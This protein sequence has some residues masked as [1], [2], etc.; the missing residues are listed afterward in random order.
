MWALLP[1]L[2]MVALVATQL[3]RDH[4]IVSRVHRSGVLGPPTRR[5]GLVFALLIVVPVVFVRF[6]G[7]EGVLA[8][9]SWMAM[10]VNVVVSFLISYTWYRYLTW[11]DPFAHEG[12]GWVLATFLL[13]CVVVPLVFPL[14]EMAESGL[15]LRLDGTLWNDWW[16]CSIAIG[17]TEEIVKLIPLLAI[18]LF[19][20]QAD[21]PFDLILY[22]SISALAFAF[23]EN[24]DYLGGSELFAVGGRTLYASVAH[25]FFTSIVAY[26]IAIARHRGRSTVLAGAGALLLAA[27]AHGFYDLWLMAPDRPYLITLLFLLA[28]MHLWVAMK[29]NLVNL[30]PHYQEHMVPKPTMFRY[31]IINALLAIFLFTYVMKFL[32]TDRH[33]AQALLLMQGGTMGATLLYLAVSFSSFRF[34]PGYIGP[35]RPKGGLWRMLMPVTNWGEDLTGRELLLRIPEKRSDVRHYMPLH[36][37]LPLRGRLRQRVVL[38][39]DRDWYLFRPERTIP[40]DGAFGEALL[41]RPHAT[42]DT[43]PDDRYVVV[44]AMVFRDTPKLVAGTARVDELEF[45]GYVHGKLI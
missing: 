39:D 41:I 8:D 37:M 23:V 16:Y 43:I 13:G 12:W 4:R 21:E 44:V 42:N 31:R 26:A 11:L 35:L 18:L 6:S 22:G 17:L 32:L 3:R 30:S 24:V 27:M 34:I 36:R 40:F 25:M 5:A 2:A 45:A 7:L 38:G 9:I 1:F 28:S 19:T 14:R 10:T 33:A 29:T 15:G 20:K